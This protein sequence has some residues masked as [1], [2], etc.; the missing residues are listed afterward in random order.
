MND[1]CMYLLTDAGENS[2]T[3]GTSFVSVIAIDT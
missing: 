1:N 2:P 3:S